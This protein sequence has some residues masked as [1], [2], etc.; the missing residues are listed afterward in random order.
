MKTLSRIDAALAV[1]I[2]MLAYTGSIYA[3]QDH[4]HAPGAISVIASTVPANGDVNPYGLVRVQKSSGPLVKGNLLVSN[5][6]DSNNLQ[7]RAR[8]SCKFRRTDRLRCSPRSMPT[9]CRDR[10]RVEL[11]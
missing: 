10:V 7:G 8:Q 3:Q 9:I 5:F 4:R 1:G 6:N 2:L 11:G